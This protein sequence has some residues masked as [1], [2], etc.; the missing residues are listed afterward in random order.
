[1]DRKTFIQSTG[2]AG[3]GLLLNQFSFASLP[4]DFPVVRVAEG[5]R[6]FT[7][8]AVEAAIAEFSGVKDKELAWL[9]NNCFP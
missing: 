8:K 9:F 7:S 4:V 3:A 6:H 5:K 1:M 2:L